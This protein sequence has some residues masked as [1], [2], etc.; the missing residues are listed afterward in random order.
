MNGVTSLQQELS[1]QDERVTPH[2]DNSIFYSNILTNPAAAPLNARTVLTSASASASAVADAAAEA[3]R[4]QAQ[5]SQAVNFIITDPSQFHRLQADLRKSS[6]I[7]TEC[8]RVV[9]DLLL[10][11][12]IENARR[13]QEE[14]TTR[15]MNDE[16]KQEA[17]AYDKGMTGSSAIRQ[18]DGMSKEKRSGWYFTGIVAGVFNKNDCGI[19]ATCT[20]A[21]SNEQR[22]LSHEYQD[23]FYDDGWRLAGR[24]TDASPQ[25]T[26][27]TSP[28]PVHF[29]RCTK[30][31]ND[32]S[33]SSSSYSSSSF[34]SNAKPGHRPA[35]GAARAGQQPSAAAAC[36]R[37]RPKTRVARGA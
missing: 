11:K 9:V 25:P 1:P 16:R 10:D 7:T 3:N 32:G 6:V 26:P 29:N 15:R 14:Q 35:Y 5:R 31:N 37:P 30:K 36:S 33:Y 27:S 4:L 22:D 17:R 8:S 20:S 19:D 18:E 13:M 28:T 12:R 24:S 21:T 2:H 34:D 23:G